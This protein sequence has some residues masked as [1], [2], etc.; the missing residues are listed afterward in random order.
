MF[1]SCLVLLVTSGMMSFSCGDTP[2]KQEVKARVED[3]AVD[4][5]SVSLTALSTHVSHILSITRLPL[6]V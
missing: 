3:T 4:K 5:L 1:S 6:S 2:Q